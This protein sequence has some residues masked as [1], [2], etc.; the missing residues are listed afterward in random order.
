MITAFLQYTKWFHSFY[1]K[2]STLLELYIINSLGNSLAKF[3][4]LLYLTIIKLTMYSFYIRNIFWSLFTIFVFF[5]N[6]CAQTWTPVN[7]GNTN[8]IYCVDYVNAST[9]FMAGANGIIKSIDGGNTWNTYPIVDLSNNPLPLSWFYDMHFFDANNGIATGFITTG[10]SEVIF[11]TTNGGL[12]WSTVSVY[13]S[14][15]WPRML[16]DIS[17][18]NATT[19]IAVG[20]NGRILRST[21]AGASWGSISSG[22]TREI[23]GV[24][25]ASTSVG[26]AV[27]DQVI[28]RT[29]NGG[30]SWSLSSTPLYDLKSVHF[31]SSTVGYAVGN[32]ILKTTDG[33]INW[34]QISNLSG[35]DIYA[36]NVDSAYI[37]NSGVYKTSNSGAFWGTQPSIAPGAYNDIDFLNLS[38]G[39]VVG[40]GG[41]VYK[42]I[43][44]G[45]PLPQIDASVMDIE[46]YSSTLCPG[47]YPVK[48]KLKNYGVQSL[49]SANINWSVN[50][51]YQ[52][53]YNWAGSLLPN[54]NT[55]Y[56]TI[57]NY[58]FDF[59]SQKIRAWTSS[60]NTSNDQFIG[61]DSTSLTFLTQRLQGTYTIGGSNPD[62][63]TFTDAV[64]RL[65]TFGVCGPVV[66]KARNGIY[67]ENIS[68]NSYSGASLA[69][70][71]SFESESGDSTLVILNSVTGKTILLN[72]SDYI[73]FKNISISSIDNYA[74]ELKN[75]ADN[76]TVSN[77]NL[78]GSNA[79][80]STSLSIVGYSGTTSHNSI[81]KNNLFL[82]GSHG[83]YLY[84]QTTNYATGLVI[85]N[86][87][88][89]GQSAKAIYIQYY[90]SPQISNNTITS[91]VISSFEGI[92]CVLVKGTYLFSK[93]KI[94][95][96]VGVGID[97][98]SCQ[99]IAGVY[100]RVE[101]NFI[102]T[103]LNTGN[104][105]TA[106]FLQ[107]S[108]NVEIINNS[109]HAM[110]TSGVNAA[111]A[112]AIADTSGFVGIKL[113][114][115]IL[116]ATGG[117][118]S[119]RITNNLINT[120]EPSVRKIFEAIGP[121]CYY[122]T[123][124]NFVTLLNTGHQNIPTWRNR[125][126]K[127]SLSFIANPQFASNNDLHIFVNGTNYVLDN[128]AINWPGINTD[129]DNDNRQSMPDI[130]ADE[131]NK[132]LLD[133]QLYSIQDTSR[134][135]AGNNS[136]FFKVINRGLNTVNSFTFNWQINGTTQTPFIWSGTLLS[137]DTSTYFS[138]GAYNFV[139]GNYTIKS[140]VS[141]PN[142]SVDGSS[143]NDTLTKIV[144]ASGMSGVYTIGS[145][146]SNYSTIANAV[147]AIATQGI[148]NPVIFEL[149]PGIYNEQIVI[150]SIQGASSFNTITFRSQ[151]NDSTSVDWNYTPTAAN[152]YVLKLNGADFIHIEKITIRTTSSSYGTIIQMSG[153]CNYNVISNCV[154]SGARTSSNNMIYGTNSLDNYN[155]FSQNKFLRGQVGIHI[156]GDTGPYV[157][158]KGNVIK[159][160]YFFNHTNIAISVLLQES[161]LIDNNTISMDTVCT[162]NS[163]GIKIFSSR[164]QPQVSNNRF[165]G[166]TLYGILW[167]DHGG[168]PYTRAKLYNNM[169]HNYGTQAYGCIVASIASSYIDVINNS[170]L[171]EG[172]TM[173]Y[174]TASDIGG[175]HSRVY[176]NIFS[177]TGSG[178]AFSPYSNSTVDASD[179]NIFYAPTANFIQNGQY[180]DLLAWRSATGFDMHSF[181]TSPNFISSNDLHV[182]I[183][184]F[185]KNNGTA[186]FLS[187][188]SNDIDHEMRDSNP[189]IGADEYNMTLAPSDAGALFIWSGMPMCNGINPVKLKFKNYGSDTLKNVLVNWTVNNVIQTPLNWS[190]SLAPLQ[191]SDT[192]IVGNFNFLPGSSYSI[193]AWTD[194]PNGLADVISVNDT[195]FINN[196]KTRLSGVLTIGGIN[197]N[198][199]NFLSA[200]AAL[201]SLGICGPV[202]FN[203]RTGVYNS[204]QIILNSVNGS[205]AINTIVFKSETGNPNDVTITGDNDPVIINGTDYLTIRDLTISG[206]TWATNSI[207][208]QGGANYNNFINNHVTGSK[209]Y[210][211]SDMD[212]NMLIDSNF[213]EVVFAMQGSSLGGAEN[214]TVFTHNKV[215]NH[216][217]IQFG[218][219]DSLTILKNEILVNVFG[220]N[221]NAGIGIQGCTGKIK[222]HKNKVMGVFAGGIRLNSV[223]G[224]AGS[225]V[226]IYN[227]A[228]SSDG[229]QNYYEG[230]SLTSSSY[231]NVYHNSVESWGYLPNGIAFA[232]AI[233]CRSF[234]NSVK[235]T[236]AS[237]AYYAEGVNSA[238]HFSDYNNVMGPAFNAFR[239][240]GFDYNTL[241]DYQTGTGKDL[242]S[243]DV[244]P[245]YVSS[246]DLFPGNPLLSNAGFSVGIADDINSNPRNMTAPTI[247]AYEL[248]VTSVNT[249]KDTNEGVRIYPNP[250]GNYFILLVDKLN[251]NLTISIS[252]AQ[253]KL[254]Y[255]KKIENALPEN[256]IKTDL[257]NGVYF[258]NIINE[259]TGDNSVKKLIIQK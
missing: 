171:L 38:N 64:A 104:I 134:I 142:G 161:I 223:N 67:T 8:D 57:G 174:N 208:I 245:M 24:S 207:L 232:T 100:G 73:Q 108:N 254:V 2:K 255:K 197:P 79:A 239:F 22:T 209:W 126:T 218:T 103:G 119:M 158:E 185:A 141:L 176:N 82:N 252:D 166:K 80:I 145:T 188:I 258:V 111:F 88:F 153:G 211:P 219:T 238:T 47:T 14:G 187:Y 63:A 117:G 9:I 241:L 202:M 149:K 121:N 183:N 78:S 237:W 115:N 62:F 85:D 212:N 144:S 50:G 214:N 130:G 27:G 11:R 189:D 44:G 17:F 36:T 52:G 94:Y 162:S 26:V 109:L 186:S 21:N 160:N 3:K 16:N 51:I 199:P 244:D 181:Q 192:T 60:P 107:S 227:N 206:T 123:G 19:G 6:S 229:Y 157:A 155:V 84:G 113:V 156:E 128:K 226:E 220:S 40:N 125:I 210:S 191:L 167:D 139:S 257:S 205:S 66:F 12:N 236:G 251:S 56:I 29:T 10:N 198:Y 246:S 233:N 225:E 34:S 234:N 32:V 154:L 99:N 92:T 194:L 204:D 242:H 131:F 259:T 200:S 173:A 152:N 195:V 249:L 72:G 69:N 77:C 31:A 101:N 45:E 147:N 164:M 46:A 215:F 124:S 228:V 143:L 76:I 28:L 90:L 256:S 112:M 184:Y 59:T 105:G 146:P 224:S 70:S 89:Q 122:T 43:T 71:V 177:N 13:N 93:N 33:G 74:I 213:I 150:P 175:L 133:V 86:N 102:R 159:D 25:F 180:S 83:I 230:I 165:N 179:Y 81:F 118:L 247:G 35:S 137:G 182:G 49:T 87:K 58:N 216:D 1:Q 127:D 15:T 68:I 37:S 138:P 221:G 140:W 132:P 248:N 129:I 120:Q 151:T 54:A 98:A 75:G 196:V 5:K 193:K 53:T 235:S 23:K 172:A 65:N 240:N 18:F 4:I 217:G 61:N 114:N 41:Q 136:P 250:A 95:T 7:T 231:I 243:I 201:N 190:G 110:G 39:Y 169:I 253:G 178:S 20:T 97:L 91:N 170:A 55:S 106:L 135:C 203:A 96:D 148:C 222:I 116:A 163:V 30:V 42:T 48:V 168:G